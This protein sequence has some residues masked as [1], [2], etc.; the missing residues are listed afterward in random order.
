MPEW[1][2][3][4]IAKWLGAESSSLYKKIHGFKQN[5][6]EIMPGDLFFALK[7]EKVDGHRYLKE[8]AT[9]GAIGAVVRKDYTG[10]NFGLELFYVKDV[11]HSLHALAKTVH[12][13]RSQRTIGVTG[14]VGKT[15]MKEFIAT[16]LSPFNVEKTPGNA[17]S[18]VGVPLSI[19]NSE[20]KAAIFVME[21]GMSQAHEIE[22]LVQ[23]A[24]PEIALVGRIALAHAA[25]FSDGI[26]GIAR[27]KHEI[28]SHPQTK[29]GILHA[30]AMQ[31]PT[32]NTGSCEKC[33]YALQEEG[34][35]A[36]FVLCS[37]DSQFFVKENAEQS[38]VFS[39]PFTAKHLCENFLGAAA[40]AR[41]LGIGWEEILSQMD[42]LR[43]YTHRFEII[44]RN[45]ITFVDD[46]YNANTASM[47][48]AL[49]NLPKPQKGGKS[50][51][52]LGAMTEL[53]S[54]TDESHQEIARI[55][56]LYVDI[57]LCFGEECKVMVDIFHNAK[58]PVEYFE[59]FEPLKTR[60]HAIAQKGDVVLLK[61]SNSKQLWRILDD[62]N[63]FIHL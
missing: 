28:L 19:L 14:S 29:L 27:A 41:S 49:T 40:V 42:K 2:F 30:Q 56:L 55:A 21:M 22:K 53:G 16:L 33:T 6:Q 59:S 38:P 8:I 25:F 62:S 61:G 15:T 43:V 32:A 44:A 54:Y 17:N 1:N 12:Q 23:I 7:G 26:Q 58:K 35:E 39:L 9:K 36:H 45:G 50:I 24:P 57:L 13:L 47:R 37:V 4:Q 34:L 31:F 60:V 48:A 51:A 52:V 46:S 11:L 5:S 10:D 18:Q 63:D 20:G 3:A